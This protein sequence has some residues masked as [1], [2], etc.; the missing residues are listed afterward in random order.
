MIHL[1]KGETNDKTKASMH[2]EQKKRL[3]TLEIYLNFYLL[4]QR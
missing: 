1:T 2:A 3:P 4:L